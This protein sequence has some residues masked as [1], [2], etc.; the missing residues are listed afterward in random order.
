MRSSRSLTLVVAAALAAARPRGGAG[1][2]APDRLPRG[3]RRR[4]QMADQAAHV[5]RIAIEKRGVTP[6]S[7]AAPT[8]RRRDAPRRS[9]RRRSGPFLKRRS[10]EGF[11]FPAAYEFQPV[12]RRGEPRRAPARDVRAALEHGRPAGGA[13]RASGRRTTSSPIASLVE[14]ETVA[15][16]RATPRR[17]RD[18]QPPRARHA[19]RDRR[20]APVRARRP[21]H[22]AADALAPPERLA[23]QHAPLQGPAADADHEPRP[24]L[25]PGR[26]EARRRR[27]PLLRPQAGQ[28]STTSSRPT[29]RS[30]AR[31]RASTATAAEAQRDAAA[32]SC[33]KTSAI[34]RPVRTA[35]A[36]FSSRSSA[37]SAFS[38]VSTPNETGH[39]GLERG[40]LEPARRPRRR[41]SRSAACRR[42]SRSRARRCRRSGASSRAPSPR[43]A[44]RTRPAPA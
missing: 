42:G 13:R 20:F 31:R 12:H 37:W 21:G 9:R 33:A 38:S 6:R 41:R 44:A 40:E 23:V 1:A 15:P 29:S 43:A 26:G 11:L 30:S 34:S 19:A 4:R 2:R 32:R 27:L 17:R 7:R 16:E 3:A 5:R 36:P 25:D 22:A 35:S 8:L 28:A 39:A 18:L 10:V 14:R 24:A